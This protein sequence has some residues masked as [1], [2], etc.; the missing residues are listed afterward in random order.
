M[1]NKNKL[2]LFSYEYLYEDMQKR[3]RTNDEGIFH[4]N[5]YFKYGEKAGYSYDSLF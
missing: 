3:R 4:L 5:I 2:V 1:N